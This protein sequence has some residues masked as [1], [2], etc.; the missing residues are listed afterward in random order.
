MVLPMI[1][2]TLCSFLV[3]AVF[4]LRFNVMVLL[5]LTLVLGPAAI[6][7]AAFAHLGA[8]EGLQ[9]FL[10]SALSLHGGYVLGSILRFAVFGTPT[11]PLRRDRPGG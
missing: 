4:G 8:I 1:D 3:G 9:A 7:L 5:P 10:F 11:M 6:A 2:F